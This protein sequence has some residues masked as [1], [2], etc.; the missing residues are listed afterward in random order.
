MQPIDRFRQ[1]W[2]ADAQIASLCEDFYRYLSDPSNHLE[3][4][5]F[6]Q[7]KEVAH[8]ADEGKIA[9]ALQYL[10]SPKWRIFQQA[11]LFF[12]GDEVYE[13]GPEEMHEYFAV[14]GFPHPV[15]GRV[16]DD[17]DEIVVA[18]SP[19]PFFAVRGQI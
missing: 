13:F 5:S 6:A 15:S 12:D 4:Y 9:Q 14:G 17:L 18:F 11:F 8:V 10:S 7:L 16:I 3:H 2:R 19:G 1:D